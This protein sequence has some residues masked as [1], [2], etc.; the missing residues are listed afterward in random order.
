MRLKILELKCDFKKED[1]LV[2][3]LIDQVINASNHVATRKQLL[4]HNA[5]TPTLPVWFSRVLTPNATHVQLLKLGVVDG[6]ATIT[7]MC[8]SRT[9]FPKPISSME[10]GM[11]LPTHYNSTTVVTIQRRGMTT[12]GRA[13]TEPVSTR[14]NTPMT[15]KVISCISSSMLVTPSTTVPIAQGHMQLPK[16]SPPKHTAEVRGKVDIGSQVYCCGPSMPYF[17]S[18]WA[19]TASLT[20]SEYL[21][22]DPQPTMAVPLNNLTLC[23]FNA[24]MVTASWS[25]PLS[26]A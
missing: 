12:T 4:E 17:L 16:F 11:K 10:T 25:M 1:E 15:T 23:S 13:M 3:Q 5:K 18:S 9:F 6:K 2:D 21:T 26:P 8:W 19:V 7:P 20:Q 14:L 22:P 24:D